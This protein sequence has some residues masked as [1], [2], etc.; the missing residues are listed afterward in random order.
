MQRTPRWVELRCPATGKLLLRY[1]P[2][3]FIIQ[4]KRGPHLT[5][6]DLLAL[7]QEERNGSDIEPSGEGC[8]D[9][10]QAHRERDQDR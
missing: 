6:F 9:V 3:M 2:S 4:V 5:T 8:A 7:D 1:L 10:T